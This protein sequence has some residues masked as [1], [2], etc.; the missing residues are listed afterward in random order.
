MKLLDPTDAPETRR[1]LEELPARIQEIDTLQV[2]LD[3][4]RT[5]AS[6]DLWL[7]TTHASRDDLERYQ[8]HPVHEEFRSWVGPRLASRAV[9]D[10][11]E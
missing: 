6:Y 10:S 2:G 11:E 8:S 1:R 3:V 5:P 4:L 7:I 9:V